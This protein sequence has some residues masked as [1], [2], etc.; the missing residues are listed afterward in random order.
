[1]KA[2]L[3]EIE[4]LT[5]LNGGTNSFDTWGDSV[6]SLLY[7]FLINE[8]KKKEINFF[9]GEH[10]KYVVFYRSGHNGRGGMDMGSPDSMVIQR[11]NEAN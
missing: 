5:V 7:F 9:H 4:R 11:V 2:E 6:R 10:G 3:K 1:M 8:F